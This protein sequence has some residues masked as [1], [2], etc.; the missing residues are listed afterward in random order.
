LSGLRFRAPLNWDPIE[1][2]QALQHRRSRLPNKDKGAAFTFE[3][4]Q[5]QD[6]S[7]GS[8]GGNSGYWEKGDSVDCR[9]SKWK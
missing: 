1:S 5:G 6:S 4:A 2:A 9:E 7:T 8:S 3:V